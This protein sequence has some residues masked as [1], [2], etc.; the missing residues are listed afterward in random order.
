MDT[1]Q[2]TW[3]YQ[4][5]KF[6]NRRAWSNDWCS[7]ERRLLS[8]KITDHKPSL[9]NKFQLLIY[10]RKYISRINIVVKQ[11]SGIVKGLENV[12]KIPHFTRTATCQKFEAIPSVVID[13]FTSPSAPQKTD[14]SITS[15]FKRG[16][17]NSH[18]CW[19]SHTRKDFH[20]KFKLNYFI[21]L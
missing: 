6:V 13:I 3:A 20:I 11:I 2:V 14:W 19:F 7:L 9:P 18:I 16:L 5:P 15:A 4:I 8:I 12:I 10:A 21:F 17:S 1:P